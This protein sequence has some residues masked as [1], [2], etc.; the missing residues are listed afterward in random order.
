V[1]DGLR[2]AFGLEKGP[3][4][5][6]GQALFAVGLLA[7]AGNVAVTWGDVHR[8]GGTDLRARVVGARALMLGIDPYLPLPAAARHEW[9]FDPH[10][11]FRDISRCPYAPPLLAVYALLCWLPYTAQRLLWFVIEW[12][13]L[14][15]SIAWLA[16]TIRPRT[17]RP[18]FVVLALVFFAG[19][20]FWRLH[21]ERGQYYSLVL[22]LFSWSVAEL[23][24][25]RQD[26][27]RAGL[28]L[29]I[30]A[31]LRPT[32]LVVVAPLWV[33][34]YRRAAAGAVA[35]TAVIVAVLWPFTGASFWKDYM[36]LVDTLERAVPALPALASM[37]YSTWVE[38][39]DFTRVLPDR[40]SNANIHLLLVRAAEWTGWPPR[41]LIPVLAKAGFLV[42][43]TLLLALSF[44]G[45]GA[46]WRPRPALAVALT[47]AMVTDHFLP[48][49]WG[50]ADI[51]YLAPLALLMPFML[52]ARG[53]MLLL[54]VLVALVFGHS[55]FAPL[56]SGTGSLLRAVLLTGGLVGW[57]VAATR[58]G[59][60]LPARRAAHG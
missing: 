40:S 11:V 38:G 47:A 3:I 12:A 17:A 46:R 33:L 28:P 42:A 27:W 9:L 43:I 19:G 24:R 7:A 50:Y 59:L 60:P 23:M 2:R 57:T 35:A 10:G 26:G 18:W 32:V 54:T 55:L 21:V 30:A 53:R 49:R 37:P 16:R 31:A 51:L 48:L 44:R 56:D 58:R 34:G 25:S 29:G 39:A 52:R 15:V 6:P 13:S 41:A 4:W 8:F 36:R 20:S 45:R 14:L 5:S 22:L 1:I